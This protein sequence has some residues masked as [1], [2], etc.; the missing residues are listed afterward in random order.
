MRTSIAREFMRRGSAS[1]RQSEIYKLFQAYFDIL[2]ST[3][4]DSSRGT[5]FYDWYIDDPEITSWLTN[6]RDSTNGTVEFLTGL[7]GI[8]KTTHL[9]NAFSLG[10]EP[11]ISHESLIIPFY[12]DN[13]IEKGTDRIIPIIMNAIDSAAYILQ[14]QFQIQYSALEFVYFI[15][16]H[17]R[18]LFGEML[19][20]D[21]EQLKRENPE[22]LIQHIKQNYFAGYVAVRL[23][24]FLNRAPLSKAIFVLDDLESS[25]TEFVTSFVVR[26][27]TIR[28]CLLNTGNVERR[29]GVGVLTSCRPSTYNDLKNHF[30]LNGQALGEQ[31]RIARPIELSALIG[32]RFD[33]AVKAIGEG[34]LSDE[35]GARPMVKDLDKWRDSYSIL[36]QIMSKISERHGELL[37]G[38]CNY[39]LRQALVTMK[40][41]LKHSYWYSG[42]KEDQLPGAF[43]IGDLNINMTE[44]SV[45]RAAVL[46]N[47]RVYRSSSDCPAV[48][49]FYNFQEE[50]VDLLVPMII[51]HLYYKSHGDYMMIDKD[52]ALEIMRVCFDDIYIDAYLSDALAYLNSSQAIFED[53]RLERNGTRH[54]YYVT[55]PRL[56]YIW[57]SLS[58][59]CAFLEFFRDDCYTNKSIMPKMDR[60]A[61]VPSSMLKGDAIFVQIGEFIHRIGHK[62]AS[63]LKAIRGR[64]NR[65]FTKYKKLFG[66]TTITEILLRGYDLSLAAYYGAF[67]AKVDDFADVAE[68]RDAARPL[69][70]DLESYL[71]SSD[72]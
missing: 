61:S 4:R 56:F 66:T 46:G 44:I 65:E 67:G 57:R 50:D 52:R 38:I 16:Q 14:K 62:E 72:P 53:A 36:K 24:Y 35:R 31:Q 2:L 18:S 3:E 13:Y 64:G 60:N 54:V 48:N 25:T 27:M 58:K 32:R 43:Q 29:F 40:G 69:I 21:F 9:R 41:I 19:L 34:A 17:R 6:I 49:I 30:E 63:L 42:F 1:H 55:R 71:T 37:V 7:K 23:K 26:I 59:S 15:E 39:D 10:V 11:S 47:N 22:Q 8:G 33:V 68:V 45:L 70:A 5:S 28:N 12:I 51:K 20:N